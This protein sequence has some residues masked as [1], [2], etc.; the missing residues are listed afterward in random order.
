M[1]KYINLQSILD[2]SLGKYYRMGFRLV[3]L[4]KEIMLVFDDIPIGLMPAEAATILTVQ[5]TCRQYLLEIFGG[6]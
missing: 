3:E 1:N 2:A 6:E 4:G 5:E